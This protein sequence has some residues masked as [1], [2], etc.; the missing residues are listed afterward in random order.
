MEHITSTKHPLC[1]QGLRHLYMLIANQDK[2]ATHAVNAYYIGHTLKHYRLYKFCIPETKGIVTA[3]TAKFY[4]ANCN[5]PTICPND[6][7][8]TATQDLIPALKFKDTRTPIHLPQSHKNSLDTISKIFDIDIATQC[9][10]STHRVYITT[11]STSATSMSKA[12]ILKQKIGHMQ[13]T[14]GNTPYHCHKT[15]IINSYYPYHQLHHLRGFQ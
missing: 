6:A 1:H 12:S 5:M 10:C 15:I 11:P 4:P 14:C 2:H 3:Q 9:P 8:V 7:I 13:V